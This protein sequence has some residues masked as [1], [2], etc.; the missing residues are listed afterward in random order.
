MA[1]TLDPRTATVYRIFERV[2][3]DNDLFTEW[4]EIATFESPSR[5]RPA[6]LEW[7]NEND[8]PAGAYR[9]E[10]TRDGYY[11]DELHWGGT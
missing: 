7:I 11:A 3:A 2:R 9:A 6:L 10:S 5:A 1:H 4:R 8:P